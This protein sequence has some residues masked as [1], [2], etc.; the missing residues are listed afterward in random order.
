M[1]MLPI[2]IITEEILPRLPAKS[3]L[4]FRCILQTLISSPESS[5]RH[6]Q[7][8]QSQSSR[9]D[10]YLIL[11]G[12]KQERDLFSFGVHRLAGIA[13]PRDFEGLSTLCNFVVGSCNGLLCTRATFTFDVSRLFLVNPCTAVHRIIHLDH[14]HALIR[15]NICANLGFGF[16]SEADD[17]KIVALVNYDDVRDAMFEGR[18]MRGDWLREHGIPRLALSI[19]VPPLVPGLINN[20]LLH[21]MFRCSSDRKHWIGPN[22]RGSSF[23]QSA[24][25]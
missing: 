1:A 16:D 23:I 2:E 21:W 3:L 14:T 10:R 11:V 4:R 19:G 25:L 6:L 24:H 15:S 13:L 12:K 22:L 8:S 20:H 7:H 5:N 17:Y 18:Y 9:P